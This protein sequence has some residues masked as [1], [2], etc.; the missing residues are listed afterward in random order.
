[1]HPLGYITSI[2]LYL[3][4]FAIFAIFSILWILLVLCFAK[5]RLKSRFKYYWL[6]CI[7]MPIL[8]NEPGMGVGEEA[9]TFITSQWLNGI[10]KYCHFAPLFFF[11]FWLAMNKTVMVPLSQFWFLLLPGEVAAFLLAKVLEVVCHFLFLGLK[12]IDWPKITQP[13]RLEPMASRFLAW[14]LN[15]YSQLALMCNKLSWH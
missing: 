2:S 11:H 5:H 12:Q 7:L 9:Q 10:K 3:Q 6:R 1:M 4:S 15:Y 8:L 13:S 14:C